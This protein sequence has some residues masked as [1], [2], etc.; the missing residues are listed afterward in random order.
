MAHNRTVGKSDEVTATLRLGWESQADQLQIEID[1]LA[2]GIGLLLTAALVGWSGAGVVVEVLAYLAGG[3]FTLV[4]LVRAQGWRTL[5]WPRRLSTGPDLLADDTKSHPGFRHAW[6]TLAA[7]GV[8]VDPDAHARSGICVALFPKQGAVEIRRLPRRTGV[9]EAIRDG[10]PLDWQRSAGPWTALVTAPGTDPHTFAVPQ[11][12]DKDSVLINIS[13]AIAWQGFAGGAVAA[14][15]G[16]CAVFGAGH[17]DVT[18]GASRL[19]VAL[20]GLP[21]CLI[22]LAVAMSSL[23]LVRPRAIM[24]DRHGFTWDD[25][26]E[27]SF[28]VAWSDLAALSIESTVVHNMNSG[29]RSSVH[30][31]MVP[32]EAGLLKRQPELKKWVRDGR[33]VLPLA[34]QPAAANAIA[35]AASTLAPDIWRGS[36][37]H[38]GHL[39]LT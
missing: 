28:T 19:A 21:F 25:P 20:V 31:V 26:R 17:G 34:D 7:V 39:G 4:G 15:F 3:L 38:L 30:V 6:S 8:L 10:A 32:K 35:K 2:I 11:V 24:L 22:G 27:Q 16:G 18:H 12:H 29:D 14:F 37:Q 1:V 13:K 23:V 36:S 33:M 5:V 9:A